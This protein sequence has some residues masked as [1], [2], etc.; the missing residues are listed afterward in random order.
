M[1]CYFTSVFD[2]RN[3]SL[4]SLLYTFWKFDIIYWQIVTNRTWSLA[5]FIWSVAPVVCLASIAWTVGLAF[6]L[7]AILGVIGISDIIH[8]FYHDKSI[9]ISLLIKD[10]S[11]DIQILLKYFNGTLTSASNAL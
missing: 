1:C 10:K 3:C 5:L 6:G 9:S 2:P 4:Y 11:R 8:Y 7:P